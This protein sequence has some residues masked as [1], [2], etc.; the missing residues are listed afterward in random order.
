MRELVKGWTWNGSRHRAP[1]ST[2]DLQTESFK[3][4]L[5]NAHCAAE[6]DW[7]A[8]VAFPAIYMEEEREEAQT[9]TLDDPDKD[10]GMT[11]LPKGLEEALLKGEEMLE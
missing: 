7:L 11:A 8:R 4:V 5:K 2:D 10:G 1:R 6:R 3:E 9:D